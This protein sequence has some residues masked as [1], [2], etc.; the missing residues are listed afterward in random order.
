L[1][2]PLFFCLTLQHLSW[3]PWLQIMIILKNISEKSIKE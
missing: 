3:H 1:F 2:N